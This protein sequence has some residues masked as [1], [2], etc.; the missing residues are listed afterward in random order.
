MSKLKCLSQN[1]L[2]RYISLEAGD[3]EKILSRAGERKVG[4]SQFV[5]YIYCCWSA[6]SPPW[7]EAANWPTA[8]LL[9]PWSSSSCLSSW[10]GG[11][12]C[13]C[14]QQLGQGPRLLQDTYLKVSGNKNTC[15]LQSAVVE[16]HMVLMELQWT[17]DILFQTVCLSN[18]GLWR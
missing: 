16:F 4:R 11:C 14:V 8:A 9:P 3:T 5:G 13:V 12:L 1:A 17:D 2:F 18:F 7:C 15:K 6:D 10:P